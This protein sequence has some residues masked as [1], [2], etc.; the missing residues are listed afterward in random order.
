VL[1]ADTVVVLSQRPATVKEAID[2]PLSRPRQR[3]DPK[4]GELARRIASLLDASF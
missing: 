1:L 3:E 2:I 4:V